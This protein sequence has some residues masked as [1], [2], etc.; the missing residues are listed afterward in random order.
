MRLVSERFNA[1]TIL[2]RNL[3]AGRG[4]KVAI[5]WGGEALTYSQVLDRACRFGRALRDLGV[6]PEQRVL[7]VLDD[8]PAFPIAFLGAIRAG[9]VPVPLTP[10]ANADELGFFL[11]DSY[12]RAVIVDAGNLDK[13]RGEAT[14]ARRPVVLVAAGAPAEGAHGLDELLEAAD[15]ALPTADTHSDDMAFWLYSS[16]STGRPKGV[17]HLQRDI[18][19]T[20]ERYAG[21]ILGITAGDVTFSSTK[22]YHAYGL[23]NA[24]SF[25][26]WAGATTV[27][28]PGR[29]SPEAV[30]DVVERERPTL[31]FS[32]PTLYNAMLNSPGAEGRDLSSVRLCVSAA[33]ALPPGV[34]RRWMDAYGLT[35][36]DGVGSTEMLHIYCSNTPREM[37]PGS[38]GKPVPGYDLALE[39]F[40][41][42][43]VGAGEP[44]NL[45]VRG[46]SA[47]A[48]YWHRHE[49]T[50]RCL[51]GEWF[52]TGDRYRKDADGFFWYEGR[53]DDMMK[54]GGL[55]VSPIAI[56]NTIGEHPDVAEVAVVTVKRD[57]LPRIKAFVVC[58]NDRK[59]DDAF[60]DE[61]RAWC[62]GRLQRYQYPHLVEF[63]DEL[64]KTQ[65]GKIQ[66]YK[67]RDQG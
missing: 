17:V 1:S 7:L 30:L 31:F 16:G 61:L 27:L 10:L 28:M 47:L 40:D 67:L 2:D 13:V 46:G 45:L 20:C 19:Y 29:P 64:P 43:P 34:W 35:I 62:K 44:G 23:G 56:E 15:P 49:Q 54:V 9:I 14:H 38:S 25:P 50:K 21:P 63:P 42:N 48:Y 22:L 26:F 60:A 59:G 24:L 32:V 12:A 33:E 58:K 3:E 65:T 37:R 8:S 5:R 57:E 36:L 51:R 39:D 53:S 66:R 55:W 11:E 52:F 6:Q 18:P 4:D 41:G